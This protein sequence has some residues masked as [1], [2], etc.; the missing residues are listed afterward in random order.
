[1]QITFHHTPDNN[2]NLKTMKKKLWT[3]LG[4]VY[5]FSI[6]PCG[7]VLRLIARFALAI[8]YLLMLESRKS[9]DIFRN[10]IGF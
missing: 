1:M 3:A 5:L 7:W 9:K 6:Y 2:F 10:L 4:L 8:A